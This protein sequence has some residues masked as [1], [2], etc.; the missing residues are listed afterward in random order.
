MDRIPL[1][2]ED[3]SYAPMSKIGKIEVK[4]IDGDVFVVIEGFEFADSPTC[5]MAA[6]R[7]LAWL[8][9]VLDA[10]IRIQQLSNLPIRSV[11]N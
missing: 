10:Q 5:R 9:D 11:V 7:S 3:A 1:S 2:Q 8:R 6:V 4:E